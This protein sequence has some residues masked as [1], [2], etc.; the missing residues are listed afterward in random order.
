MKGLIPQAFIDDV[1]ARTDLVELIDSRVPLKKSGSNFSACCPFHNEKTASFSV[2]QDKQFFHCFG[3]GISGNAISFLMEYDRLEFLDAVDD[4]ATALGLEIPREEGTATVAVSSDLYDLMAKAS[5]YYQQLLQ[6]NADA[7]K[8]AEYL[9][10]RGLSAEVARDFGLGYA[11]DQWDGLLK[12]LAGSA[13]RQQKYID[14]GML[15]KKDTGRC[16]DRFRERIMFPIRDRRGKVIAFGGRILDQG[17]PKYLNSPETPIFH[18]GRELYGLYEARQANRK[19]QNIL[20]VEGYMDVVALAQFD[21][22]NAVATL[23]TATNAFHLQQLFKV[24]NELIFCFDGDKA[25]LAAAWKAL[26]IALPLIRGDR[27]VRFMFLPKGEDPDSMVRKTGKDTFLQQQQQATPLSQ[28]MF[29][30]LAEG[31]DLSMP[32]GRS[33]YVARIKKLLDKVADPVLKELLIAELGERVHLPVGQLSHAMNITNSPATGQRK[34][35][36]GK[37]LSITPMRMVIGL[38]VQYPELA[39][40]VSDSQW[41]E[42]VSQPGAPLLKAMLEML[43]NN[44]H[45]T[46][47]A[48]LEHWRGSEEH[49]QLTTLASWEHL[50]TD[51]DKIV[52]IFCDAIDKLFTEI[53][54]IRLSELISRQKQQLL[55]ENEK[56][57]LKQL[58]S[59]SL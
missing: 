36:S 47:G 30:H 28:F 16:Y 34:K 5:Q 35:L 49:P 58:L 45:L 26:E 29:E 27:L 6:K 59:G 23:G 25:G 33:S 40:Q 56:L 32:D 12:T 41:V 31:T 10:K 52:T 1:L 55:S 4:L 9:K 37:Q 2:N 8:A 22:K 42:H 24:V 50:I 51:Q 53:R 54:H 57:E 39:R 7:G 48:F 19:L 20:I 21:I 13:D 15:I 43:H 46:T 38:L 14:T 18:K 44:P 11:S 17:E 3:C